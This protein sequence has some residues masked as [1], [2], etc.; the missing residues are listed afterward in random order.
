M[1]ARER[2]GRL[3][4]AWAWAVSLHASQAEGWQALHVSGPKKP[5][6]AA[7]NGKWKSRRARRRVTGDKV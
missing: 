7:A 3:S 5:W 4:R 2:S 6:A 1:S